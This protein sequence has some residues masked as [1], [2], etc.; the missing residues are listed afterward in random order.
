MQ[1]RERSDGNEEMVESLVALPEVAD[2]ADVL[3]LSKKLSSPTVSEFARR[4]CEVVPSEN[5]TRAKWGWHKLVLVPLVETED[6]L[7]R[8]SCDDCPIGS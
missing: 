1:A 8:R 5:G 6:P 3:I 2:V 4:C 7:G